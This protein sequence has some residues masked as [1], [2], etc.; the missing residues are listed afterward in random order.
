M[1]V[2]RV[3]EETLIFLLVTIRYKLEGEYLDKVEM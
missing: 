1:L 3:M 2:I